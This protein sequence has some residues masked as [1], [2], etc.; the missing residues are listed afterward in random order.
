MRTVVI[1]SSDHPNHTVLAREPQA[2]PRGRNADGPL[3]RP[4]WPRNAANAPASAL[5]ASNAGT[6]RT[7]AA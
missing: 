2:Y 7:Q 3:P 5:N 4:S 6:P 1:A